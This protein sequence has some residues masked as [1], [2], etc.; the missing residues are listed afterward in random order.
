MDG[1][2]VNNLP[3]EPLE[4][5]CDRIIGVHTNP[6][7][8]NFIFSGMKSLLERTFLLTVNANVAQRAP[9]CDVFLE[10]E[11]LKGFKVFDFKNVGEVYSQTA[12]WLQPL[13][14]GILE[15]LK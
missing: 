5:S 6:I 8:Q 7:D 14:P 9:L 15:K 10:P 1:G 2:P 12:Q 3:V 13:L 11:C 4:N